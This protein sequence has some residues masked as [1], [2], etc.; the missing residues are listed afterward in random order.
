MEERKRGGWRE[1]G[2]EVKP[3]HAAACECPND[4]KLDSPIAYSSPHVYPQRAVQ[5]VASSATGADPS[6]YAG[7]HG[8]A[9]VLAAD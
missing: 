6:N 2:Q 9:S 5:G 1:R 4:W 3:Y 7:S 8:N